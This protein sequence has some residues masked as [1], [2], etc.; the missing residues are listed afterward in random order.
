MT[1]GQRAETLIAELC[2]SD[3]KDLDVEAIAFDAGLT[4]EYRDLVGCEATLAGYKDRAIASIKP[5]TVRGRERFSIGHELGH[6]KM[7]RGQSFR[8]RV[9]EVDVNIAAKRAIERDAD[10]FAAHLLMPGFLFNPAVKSIGQ[11]SF[12]EIEQLAAE[13]QTSALATSLRLVNVDTLPVV[14]ACYSMAGK[15]WG[16]PAAHVPRRWFLKDKLDPDSFAYDLLVQGKQIASLRKQSGEVWF[17]NDDAEDHELLEHCIPWRSGEVLVI[18]YLS[19]AMM[20]AGFDPHVGDRRY[21]EHGSFVRGP[22]WKRT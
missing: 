18:L 13:F 3:P 9:E 22:G 4:I 1:P 6:W 21:N 11:P 2:I 16:I 10:Q 20:G 14:L 5:S 19:K 15:R 7:H 17:Q 12:R 8:C